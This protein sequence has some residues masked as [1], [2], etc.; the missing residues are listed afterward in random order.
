MRTR[1]DPLIVVPLD[2]E[3]HEDLQLR[4]RKGRHTRSP[5]QHVVAPLAGREP[6]IY[7]EGGGGSCQVGQAAAD[8]GQEG[9]AVRI[10]VG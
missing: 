8:L 1:F 4:R 2:T 7:A 9:L 5:F 3:R 6:Q 10:L